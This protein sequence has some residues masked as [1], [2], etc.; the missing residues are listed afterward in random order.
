VQNLE[1]YD[2]PWGQ[3]RAR[4]I[5]WTRNL[6]FKVKDLSK[7][8]AKA[9]VLFYPGCTYAYDPRITQHIQDTA[10]LMHEAG[11][12]FGILGNAEKCCG[13]TAFNLGYVSV[14][15]K[16]GEDNIKTFNGLGIKKIVTPCS[17]CYNTIGNVYAQLAE[18]EFTVEHSVVML[19]QLVKEKKLKPIHPVKA[20]VTYHDPCHLG[21]HGHIFDAPREILR[22]IP[23]IKLVEMNRIREYSFCCG[24]GGGARTGKLDFAQATARKRVQEAEFTGAKLLVTACP[25]CEQNFLDS[26]DT[27]ETSLKL[28]D[29]VALLKQSVLGEPEKKKK[30]EAR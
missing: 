5:N 17:G 27:A 30:K 14:L 2:N 18:C 23:G 3:P 19:A 26:L 24:G 28:V 25:F 11:V 22:A 15:E 12:D 13:S 8:G 9:E 20:V 16:Y 10:I 6:G 4:R 29:V 21:R 7:K 1:A